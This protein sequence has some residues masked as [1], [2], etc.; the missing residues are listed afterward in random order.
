MVR[1]FTYWLMYLL[2]IK[3]RPPEKSALEAVLDLVPILFAMILITNLFKHLVGDLRLPRY[4]R[5]L[6]RIRYFI[7]R[8]RV[9]VVGF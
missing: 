6:Y 5:I 3:K 1:K 9:T 4:K 7:R 8:L 2:H